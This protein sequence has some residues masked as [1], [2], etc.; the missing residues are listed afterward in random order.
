MEAITYQKYSEGFN[1][2]GRYLLDFK[3]FQ[4]R[5]FP[6]PRS[7]QGSV[8]RRGSVKPGEEVAGCQ[9]LPQPGA[10]PR[11]PSS[12]ARGPLLCPG[13][14]AVQRGAEMLPH[15]SASPENLGKVFGVF[16]IPAVVCGSLCFS[17]AAEK[18][19]ISGPTGSSGTLQGAPRPVSR[20]GPGLDRACDT[21]DVNSQAV[22]LL[23]P[24]L[25]QDARPRDAAAIL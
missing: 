19:Y 23:L 10:A 22:L 5:W 20:R 18:K 17:K 3:Y 1:V 8:G 25:A 4:R 15:P 12:R 16:L 2:E 7:P 24:S 6:A 14:E 11:L 9:A 21:G 13:R